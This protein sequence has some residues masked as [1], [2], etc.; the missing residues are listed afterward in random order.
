MIFVDSNVFVIDLRYPRDPLYP[1]NRDFL[2][3]IRESGDGAT[4]LA[5]LLEVAGILS[6]N[7]NR[8]QLRAL[9]TYFPQNYRVR[10]FPVPETDSYLPA[11]PISGLLELMEQRCA[12]GDALVLH[13]AERFATPKSTFV[14]WDASHFAGKTSLAV[15][16]PEE[17]CANRPA[18]PRP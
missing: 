10:V 11:T 18:L 13:L 9:V 6:F 7:L 16:T 17:Y 5:N 12:F 4:T 14:T 15:M 8:T 2:A 1:A 3:V